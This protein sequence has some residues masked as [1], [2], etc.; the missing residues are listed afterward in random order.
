MEKK[1]E[2]AYLAPIL[3]IVDVRVE[4]GFVGSQMEKPTEETGEW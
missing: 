4:S 2:Q 3:V 1:N